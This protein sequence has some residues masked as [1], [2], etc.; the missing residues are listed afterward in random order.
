MY[1]QH[2]AIQMQM[3]H[4]NW[5]KKYAKM[6]TTGTWEPLSFY[7]KPC[8]LLREVTVYRVTECTTEL[9]SR[10]TK[11]CLFRRLK[12][13]HFEMTDILINYRERHEEE[14]FM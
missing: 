4:K 8:F 9:C 3:C 1:G 7:T 5:Y 13:I 12:E 14:D 2:T 6:E 10:G 11:S